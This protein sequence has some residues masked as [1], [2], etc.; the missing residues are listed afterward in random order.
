M[1]APQSIRHVRE[2]PIMRRPVLFGSLLTFFVVAGVVMIA[3]SVLLQPP[4]LASASG[5]TEIVH[6]FY[7]AAN[8]TIATGDMTAL[9]AVVAP[10]FVD[11]DPVPAMKPDRAGLEGYLTALHEVVPD[12]ELVV[13]AVVAG[14]DQAMARVAVRGGQGPVPLRDAIVAQPEPWGAVDV[15][16]IAGGKVVERWSQTDDLTLVRPVT[17]I[18]L[19]IPAPLP[20]VL[21]LDRFTFE[22]DAAWNPSPDGPRLI[23][24]E[25][26]ALRLEVTPEPA[27]GTVPV[28]GSE[29]LPGKQSDA[30]QVVALSAGGS[31]LVPAGASLAMTNTGAGDTRA[32]VV[33]FSVPR[34]PGGAPMVDVLPPGVDGQTLAGNL[35][36]DVRMGPAELVL[37]QVTLARNARLSLASADGPVLVAVE[38]GRLTVEP[39]GKGWLRRGSDGGSVDLDEQMM[40][41][42]DGLLMHQGG[43]ATLQI[44]G[45]SPAVLHVLTLRSLD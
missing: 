38:S 42:G 9:H 10:H 25:T 28:A 7:A 12:M 14:G 13:E 15:F 43:L 20:R 30:A 16:R 33:T 29:S 21:S 5:N 40:T 17:E 8:E 18:A 35:S 27:P 2:E 37:A 11:T 26:G 36:T 44:A 34:S 4:P 19:D 39:W 6:R 24:L 1:M 45:D 32:L 41:R 3:G 23:F 31:S 22:P